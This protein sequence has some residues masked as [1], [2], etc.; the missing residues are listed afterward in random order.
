MG[1][2]KDEIFGL[3]FV[4]H[5][6]RAASCTCRIK[7]KTTQNLSLL[8]Q[9]TT[10]NQSKKKNPKSCPWEIRPK[11][12]KGMEFEQEFQRLLWSTFEEKTGGCCD[13]EI[14]ADV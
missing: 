2:A 13:L 5:N 11:K 4:I 9:S 8:F 14:V 1:G 7:V 10:R 3:G 6:G 12:K